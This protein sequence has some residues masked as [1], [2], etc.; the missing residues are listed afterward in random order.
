[1]MPRM[2]QGPAPR[3]ARRALLGGVLALPVLATGCGVRLEEDAPRVP[4]VPTRTPLL[5]EDRL[6]LLTTECATLAALASDTSGRT[7]ADLVPVHERQHTVLRTSLVRMGVPLEVVDGP[8]PSTPSATPATSSSPAPSTTPPTTGTGTPTASPPASPTATG[9][10]GDPGDLARA[11]GDS[12]GGAAACSAASE[13]LWPTLAAL[14]A[15]RFAATVLLG[16]DAPVG[17]GDPVSAPPVEE[18]AAETQGA[19]YFLQVVAARTSGADGK[20]ARATLGR[21]EKL[22]AEQVDGG[23]RP[24]GALGHP[25]PFDVGSPSDAARLARETLGTLRAGYGPR[26]DALVRADGDAGW[27]AA[28]RWLGT[29]EA[30][31]HRWGLALQPFP[32][33]S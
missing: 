26:L 28:T 20:R 13:E 2:R 12:A 5:A 21:L 22:L 9:P 3:P 29:V 24:T 4:L 16:G 25:L 17:P 27:T 32:G 18:L 7:A 11:E 15:Q 23:P 10:T 6:V 30:E 1:M 31:C 33:L 14:H 19:V 8:E